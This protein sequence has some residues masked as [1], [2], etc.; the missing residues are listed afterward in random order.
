[1][2]I[3]DEAGALLTGDPDLTA[4]YLTHE[5]RLVTR[6][7]AVKEKNHLE[8]MVGTDGLR[9]KVVDTPAREAWDEYET[10]GVYHLYTAEELAA[11][12]APTVAEQVE[13]NAA[14][15]EELAALIA[16][17]GV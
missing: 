10:V 14:A 11:Q 13:A 1:M 17:G 5:Q 6:H 2:K 8:V 16:G 9:R 7:K 15:I 3:Y 4:G 12:N